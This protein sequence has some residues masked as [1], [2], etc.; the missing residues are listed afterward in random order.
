LPREVLREINAGVRSV[1]EAD[2]RMLVQLLVQRSG[3]PMPRWNVPLRDG[4]GRFIATPDARPAR[5]PRA[6]RSPPP[7]VGVPLNGVGVTPR[8]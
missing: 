7:P 8:S 3:L 1:A 2:A 5:E 4:T 6:R